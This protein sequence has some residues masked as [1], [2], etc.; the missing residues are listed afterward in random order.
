VLDGSAPEPEGAMLQLPR[1]SLA[2][3]LSHHGVQ[4]QSQ[5][6]RPGTD[7]GAEILEAA[8]AVEAD[9][10]VMGAWGHSRLAELALGGTTRA[11]FQTSDIPL[12]VA[13]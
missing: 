12:L 11:L 4:T 7:K 13:H 6:F 1:F 8:H 10:I 9:L 2:Q 3:H 5:K